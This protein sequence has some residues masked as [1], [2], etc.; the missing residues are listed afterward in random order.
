[1]STRALLHLKLIFASVF[2]GMT[3]VF[4]RVL[5]DYHAPYAFVFARFLV[6]SLFLAWFVHRGPE[7]RF[8][9]DRRHIVTFALLGLTGVCLHSVLMFMGVEYTPASRAAVIWGTIAIFVALL[10]FLCC[11]KRF[12]SGAITGMASGFIGLAVVVTDGDVLALLRTE[13]GI[14]DL[15]LLGSALAWAIYSIVGRPLLRTCS[16]LLI[17]YYATLFGTVL[18]APF[19]VH[20]LAAL[21]AIAGDARA[22][23]MIFSLGLVNSALGFLWYNQAVEQLGAVTTAAYIN[24]VPIFGVLMSTLFLHEVPTASLLAGGALVVGGLVLIERAEKKTF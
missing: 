8:M 15:L 5:A 24:L 20:D 16:P 6:A 12:S 11:G 9:L 3:P 17:T 7:S 10:D 14:G 18:L 21:P 22:L 1:M 19:V 13:V 2:W 23:L 4:G